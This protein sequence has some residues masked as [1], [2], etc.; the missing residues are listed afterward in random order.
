MHDAELQR[1]KEIELEIL[2]EFLRICSAYQI[3][4]FLSGGTCLGAI[5]HQGFI[6]WD[7]DIDISMSRKNYERFAAVAQTELDDRYVFQSCETEPNCGLVFGKI[8]KKGTVY[9]EAYSHHIDMSQGVWIDIFPYDNLPNDIEEQQRL[10]RKVQLLKNLYIVKCGYKLPEG[11]G[12]AA[13]PAYYAAKALCAFLPQSWLIDKLQHAMRQHEGDECP[14]VF[15][16][17]GA[18]APEKERM[19][20]SML[21][22]Y[23]EVSFEGR[24]CKTLKDYD[25]YLASLYGD[26]MTLPP[27]DQR[28][29][30]VHNVYEFVAEVE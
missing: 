22:E 19:P 21:A 29:A 18:Y 23:A 9:S 3:D 14:F 10:Y 15:P 16:Y 11:K 12:A 2:D 26:Y 25:R 17:G 4:Y 28:K 27:V 7:D 20:A 30:G 13:V 5:R 24:T 6:P 8:R 1:I